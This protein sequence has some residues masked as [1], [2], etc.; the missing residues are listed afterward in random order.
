MVCGKVESLDPVHV[1]GPD[2]LYRG[3]AIVD[4][5]ASGGLSPR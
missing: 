2:R 3:S 1:A 4:K 5:A